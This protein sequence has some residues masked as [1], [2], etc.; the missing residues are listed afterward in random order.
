MFNLLP[1][2]HITN[3]FAVLMA[4]VELIFLAKA[5]LAS[6]PSTNQWTFTNNFSDHYSLSSNTKRLS[7][8][9]MQYNGMRERVDISLIVHD[10]LF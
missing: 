5:L 6:E 10:M 7:R 2:R 1:A 8:T 9:V 3:P 4:T